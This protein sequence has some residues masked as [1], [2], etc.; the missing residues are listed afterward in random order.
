[1]PKHFP[2]AHLRRIPPGAPKNDTVIRPRPSLQTMPS[3]AS[4]HSAVG[5]EPGSRSHSRLVNG[6]RAAAADPHGSPSAMNRPPTRSSVGSTFTRSLRAQSVHAQSESKTV[7]QRRSRAA[8]LS[9]SQL[10]RPQSAAGS[11]RSYPTSFGSRTVVPAEIGK[12]MPPH[13]PRRRALRAWLRDVLSV[14]GVGHHKETAAFLLAGSIVP[15]DSECAGVFSP[16]QPSS[17]AVLIRSLAR[18]VIDIAKREA[19]DDAR[20]NARS[21]DAYASVES[22]RV[23]RELFSVVEDEVIHGEGLGAM[24]EAL[25]TTRSM[26]QLPLKYQ[27]VL[28]SLRFECVPLS[29][30][31]P[32]DRC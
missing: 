19:I 14:R 8:S 28:E 26:D 15:R 24:S 3:A 5:T 17:H 29:L 20:R 1:M 11:Y 12:K 10:Q 22:V 25:R 32:P 31:T 16:L 7:R 18:S 4:L 2:N 9:A 6:L 27:K 23:T 30:W 13:D 21:N